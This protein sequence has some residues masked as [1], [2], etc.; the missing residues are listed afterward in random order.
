M[1]IEVGTSVTVKM[2]DIDEKVREVK[3][4]RMKKELAVLYYLAHISSVILL[5]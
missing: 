3:S 2:G 5:S 1:K 4:R